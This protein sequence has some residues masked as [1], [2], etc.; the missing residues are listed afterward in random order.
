MNIQ[1][2]YLKTFK[3]N[4]IVRIINVDAQNRISVKFVLMQEGNRVKLGEN[5]YLLTPEK[6]SYL[7]GIP[8]VFTNYKTSEPLNMMDVSNQVY[9]PEFYNTAIE[10][11]VV[12]ELFKATEKKPMQDLATMLSIITLLAV[13]YLTYM[14]ITKFD[15]INT[16]LEQLQNIGG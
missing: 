13:G 1:Q 8:T 7:E 10:A 14:I 12:K 5:S 16:I 2:W 9:T 3:R 11:Q 4:E 6:I 15:E